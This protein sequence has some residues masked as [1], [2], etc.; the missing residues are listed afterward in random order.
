MTPRPLARKLFPAFLAIILLCTFG[1]AAYAIREARSF[2]VDHVAASLQSRAR[3]VE[4]HLRDQPALKGQALQDRIR[5]LALAAGTRITLIDADPASGKV[6]A[7]SN[8]DPET[9]NPHNERPE[10]IAAR[11]SG[12][13]QAVRYSVDLHTDMLYG[14][15]LGK[16]A[17]GSPLIIRTALPLTE[18]DQAMR[19]IYLKILMGGAALAAIAAGIGVFFVLRI[20]RPLRDIAQGATRLAAGELGNKLP[21]PDVREFAMLAETLNHMARHSTRR[22]ARWSPAETSRRPCFRA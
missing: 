8:V 13:G 4:Q 1:M 17:Q 19:D 11:T 6:L 14:A 20:A 22:S 3:L 9:M 18:I 10:V 21:V 2:Y 16:D 7:E 12:A 5:E 15:V